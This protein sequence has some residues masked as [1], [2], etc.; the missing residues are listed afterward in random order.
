MRFIAIFF[1]ATV[2]VLVLLYATAMLLSAVYL[3]GAPPL[4]PADWDPDHRVA[5]ATA[6]LLSLHMPWAIAKWEL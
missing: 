2:V 6:F 5:F 4:N 1:A 3:W